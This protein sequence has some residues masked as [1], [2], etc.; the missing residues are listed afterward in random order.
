[1]QEILTVVLKLSIIG[2]LVTAM[3]H[4]GA[5]LTLKQILEPLRS[6]RLLL[7]SI[8]ASYILVPLTAIAITRL[9][10]IEQ[11]LR[12][13]LVLLSMTAGSEAGPKIIGTAKGNIAFS[14]ALLCLQ[15]IVTIIYV[16]MVLSLLLPEV[17][18][19]HGKL[20]FKLLILVLLPMLLG[21]FLKARYEPIAERLNPFMQ[22]ASTVCM[23]LMAFLIIVLNFREIVRLIGSGALFAGALFVILSFMIGYLL[24]GPEQDTRRTLGFM[25]GAR[26][27]SISLMIASQVFDNPDV[28]LMITLTVIM[29]L[30]L[31]LP[32][33]YWFG[34]RAA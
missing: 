4:I 10:P 25:S 20:L 19:D 22:R 32:T 8:G 31:L 7:S 14:V 34:R 16:P 29:M 21:L 9:I 27:S 24:G 3:V 33:A 18:I 28:L 17:H 1:M 5:S 15:L 26:N 6:P 2:F 11:P 30:V 23:L 13:G 12:I